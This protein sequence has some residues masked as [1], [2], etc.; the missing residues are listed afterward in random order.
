MR[1]NCALS[2]QYP[3]AASEQYAFFCLN[4]NLLRSMNLVHQPADALKFGKLYFC[5]T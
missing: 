3:W 2:Y 1:K 4:V 5:A